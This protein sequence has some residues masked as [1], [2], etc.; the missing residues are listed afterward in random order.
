MLANAREGQP[1]DDVTRATGRDGL[2]VSE[3]S[4]NQIGRPSTPVTSIQLSLSEGRTVQSSEPKDG[5]VLRLV[6]MSR[7]GL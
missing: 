7:C 5:G 2:S 1:V 6:D 3:S 4:L